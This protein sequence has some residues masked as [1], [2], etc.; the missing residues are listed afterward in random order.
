MKSM[1]DIFVELSKINNN[2]YYL[3]NT[4]NLGDMLIEYSQYNF[5]DKYNLKYQQ[6]T[7]KNT[8]EIYN[9]NIKTIYSSILNID[10]PYNIVFSG[11]AI[12]TLFYN[13]Q[14][15][16]DLYFKS[17]NLNKCIILP[18]SFYKCDDAIKFF[19]ERFIIFCREEQSYNYCRSLNS[20]SKF[21]LCDDMAFFA[22]INNIDVLNIDNITNKKIINCYE[23]INA[24]KSLVGDTAYFIRNDKEKTNLKIL[25]HVFDLSGHFYEKRLNITY[26]LAYNA[27]QLLIYAISQFKNIVTNR[28]HVAIAAAMLNKNVILYDNNY[29]KSSNIYK[30]SLYKYKNVQM[31]Y[32]N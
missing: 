24:Y 8:V 25:N 14:Q 32:D 29:R 9:K 30:Q 16:I 27:T 17:K 11:G 3:A 5:F 4:G 20:K 21:I 22:D 7:N 23:K 18:S 2:F 19:D 15:I 12:W 28:L 6:I 26:E 13:Y 1:N 10:K 31:I